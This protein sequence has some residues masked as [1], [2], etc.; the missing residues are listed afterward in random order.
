MIGS[1]T[2]QYDRYTFTATQSVCTTFTLVSPN[3]IN[4]FL[5]A[6]SPSFNPG[7]IPTDYFADAGTSSSTQTLSMGI[8]AGETYSVTVHD[9]PSG[10]ASGSNYNLQFSGC[11]FSSPIPNQPPVAQAHDVSVVADSNHTASASVD[12]GSYDPD[13]GDIIRLTQTPPG[14][15]PVGTTSVVL[16]VVDSQGATAQANAT[17]TVVDPNF[18]FGGEALPG[19][20]VDAGQSATQTITIR[21][22]PAPWNSLVTLA[23]SG[24]PALTTCTFNPATVTPGNSN[25]TTTLRVAT[26]PL[27][28]ALTGRQQSWLAIWLGFS[29]LWFLVVASSAGRRRRVLPSM[30]VFG[31]LSL[32]LLNCGGRNTELAPGGTPTGT[33][34]ITVTATSGGVSHATTFTLAVN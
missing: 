28:A 23:C 19:K 10:A 24:L 1:D 31:F 15:Y 11:A 18:D 32:T 29:T 2:R 16:T 5:D 27:N 4:L 22:N 20:T 8:S 34:T 13:Q 7:D 14:P 12:N 26:T 21:P 6:Y 33:Y 9:V 3:G 30:L 17:V 25:A